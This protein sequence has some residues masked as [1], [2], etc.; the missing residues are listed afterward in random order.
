[1][2]LVKTKEKV[3]KMDIIWAAIEEVE[4]YIT[5]AYLFCMLGI[6]PLFYKEQYYKIGDAKFGFFWKTSIL[7]I[8]VSLIFLL[9]KIFI[10]RIC[11]NKNFQFHKWVEAKKD[12][13]I[14]NKTKNQEINNRQL[15]QQNV[16]INFLEELVLFQIYKSIK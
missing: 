8:S 5:L 9:V 13:W 1:M 15:K 12:L 2:K 3:S 11:I 4:Q 7:F 6:F 10:E 14:F 16:V